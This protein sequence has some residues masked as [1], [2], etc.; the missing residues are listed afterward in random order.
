MKVIK[1]PG[2]LVLKKMHN[3]LP[4]GNNSAPFIIIYLELCIYA[5]PQYMETR[6]F[7]ENNKMRVYMEVYS[8]RTG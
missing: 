6:H 1:K 2:L 8:F 4:Q 3:L 7:Y 5:I